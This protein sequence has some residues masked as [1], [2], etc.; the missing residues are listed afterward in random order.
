MKRL[1]FWTLVL[2]G[3]LNR[4]SLSASSEPPSVLPMR[5]ADC[6]AVGPAD[7]AASTEYGGKTYYFRSAACRDEFLT[8]PERFSQLYDALLELKAEGKP[9]QKPKPAHDASMVPS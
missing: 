3:L 1:M 9:L 5:P 6:V 4:P 7:A 2:G 8:D